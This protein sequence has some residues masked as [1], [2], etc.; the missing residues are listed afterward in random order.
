MKKIIL[1]LTLLA[2]CFILPACSNEKSKDEKATEKTEEKKDAMKETGLETPATIAQT[3]CALNSKITTAATEADKEKAKQSLKDYEAW[4]DNKYK[5]DAAMSKN[6]EAEV[7]K[8][9]A[10]SEGR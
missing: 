4:I 5:G 9:E 10:A 3:W 8:C 6:I 7:E 1:G 2:T